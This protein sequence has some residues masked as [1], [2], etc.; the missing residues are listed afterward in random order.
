MVRGLA[1]GSA[2][3]GSWGSPK[4]D[5]PGAYR[6]KPGSDVATLNTIERAHSYSNTIYGL[7]VARPVDDLASLSAALEAERKWLPADGVVLIMTSIPNL[8]EYLARLADSAK[9]PA[10]APASR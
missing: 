1:G 7:V 10:P 4:D 2:W 8:G 9:S 3:Y 5:L 6:A